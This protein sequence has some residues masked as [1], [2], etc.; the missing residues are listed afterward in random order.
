MGSEMCIR[1]RGRSGVIKD[2]VSVCV[3]RISVR[4]CSTGRKRSVSRVVPVIGGSFH[5][6]LV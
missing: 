2:K 4:V 1:D 6:S 3:S 5:S